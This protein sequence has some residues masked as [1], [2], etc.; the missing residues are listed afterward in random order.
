MS[1]AGRDEYEESIVE[2]DERPQTAPSQRLGDVCAIIEAGAETE[3]TLYPDG[4]DGVALMT[5]WLTAGEGSF[6]A[7][8]EMR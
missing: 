4:V 8:S 2:P 7:L 5:H 3:C 1:Y 6:V